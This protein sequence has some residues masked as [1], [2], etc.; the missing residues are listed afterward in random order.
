M[1]KPSHILDFSEGLFQQVMDLF[2]V[3]LDEKRIDPRLANRQKNK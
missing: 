3:K 2:N 1:S